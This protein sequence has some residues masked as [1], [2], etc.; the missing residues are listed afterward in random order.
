MRNISQFLA[1]AM[2]REC[3]GFWQAISS[4]GDFIW[5]I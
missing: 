5:Y 3:G 1:M 4:T 2:R